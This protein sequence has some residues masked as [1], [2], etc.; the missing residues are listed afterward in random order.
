MVKTIFS[1]KYEANTP[2]ASMRKLRPVAEAAELNGYAKI[3]ETSPSEGIEGKLKHIHNEEYVESFSSGVGHLASTNGWGWSPEIRD[4]VFSINQGQLD[5][6][7]IALSDGISANVAQGFHHAGI[8]SGCGFCTFNGLALVASENPSKKVFVLDCDE[9]GGNGTAEFTESLD[10]LS[11]V[12][13]NGSRFGCLENERT[14]CIT[15]GRVT[16]D[17]SEYDTALEEAFDRIKKTSPDLVIYQ[18]GADP[19]IDDP[20]GSLG[21]TTEQMLYRD[22]KVFDFLN[23]ESVPTM[24]VLAGGYQ[25]P[26]NEKLVPLHLNTFKSAYE[27]YFK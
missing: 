3:Q 9:H 20:L 12:T 4:G 25:E 17:F 22:S 26:I 10:N 11:Q 8:E 13:I 18:A 27:V 23:K 14:R 15:L 21:M 16:D 7:K 6:A 5:A 19:H 24:F 2:T 1:E